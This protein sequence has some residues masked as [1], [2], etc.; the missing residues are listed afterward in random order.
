VVVPPGATAITVRAVIDPPWW[1]E[2]AA[3]C[4]LL[5]LLGAV[6]VVVRR[7]WRASAPT[8]ATLSA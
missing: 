3:A 7:A 8:A 2:L 4:G 1:T 5:V 6:G